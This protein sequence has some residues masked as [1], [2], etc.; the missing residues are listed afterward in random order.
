MDFILKTGRLWKGPIG[1]IEL[2]YRFAI[3]TKEAFVGDIGAAHKKMQALR[4][5]QGTVKLWESTPFDYELSCSSGT[6][7][8]R[9]VGKNVEPDGDVPGSMSLSNASTGLKL[10][11]VKPGMV[12]RPSSRTA[13]SSWRDPRWPKR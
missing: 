3:P 11:A 6:S 1:Q 5:G 10:V 4:L 2:V 13:A 9:M 8:L 12:A 7:T